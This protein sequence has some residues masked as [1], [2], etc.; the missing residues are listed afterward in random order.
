MLTVY[1]KN[2]C[3]FCVMAKNYLQSK[4]INFREINIEQ[5]PEAREFIQKQGLRTVPQIFMD[6]KIFV[7]GGWTGLSKMTAEDIVAEIDL[8]H[9]LADQTL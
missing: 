2:N 7:E 1:S 6:G 8:R 5:D 9:S 4:N 3:P